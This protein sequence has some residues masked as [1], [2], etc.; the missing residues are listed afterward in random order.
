MNFVSI[1]ILLP[2]SLGMNP[3]EGIT[4]QEQL[5]GFIKLRLLLTSLICIH[6]GDEKQCIPGTG[7]S[8]M[9]CAESPQR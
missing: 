4:M 2:G 6:A 7:C 8:F 5:S 3:D 1:N 9:A